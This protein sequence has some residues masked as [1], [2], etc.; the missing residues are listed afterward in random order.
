M[1]CLVLF[2]LH[3]LSV[4]PPSPSMV[5]LSTLACFCLDQ[6]CT[7]KHSPSHPRPPSPIPPFHLSKSCLAVAMTTSCCA[8]LPLPACSARGTP[9]C[10]C[11][12]PIG[13]CP[14]SRAPSVTDR[15]LGNG[16]VHQN[17]GLL[18]TGTTSARNVSTRS[19]GRRFPWATTPPSR[20]RECRPRPG[21]VCRVPSLSLKDF[22][23]VLCEPQDAAPHGLVSDV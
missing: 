23:R 19:R 7:S 13:D 5:V 22:T 17:L 12:V 9:P 16:V 11:P 2:P 10:P 4:L 14:P 15:A 3:H 6:P 20:K 21:R 18:L 1:C 8:A